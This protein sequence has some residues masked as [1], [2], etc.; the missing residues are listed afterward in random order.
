MPPAVVKLQPCPPSLFG[1]VAHMGC[2]HPPCSSSCCLV[3]PLGGCNCG[4]CG[5]AL[6]LARCPCAGI[7]TGWQLVLVRGASVV[8]ALA[9]V[10]VG[11]VDQCWCWRGVLALAL[12]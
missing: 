3:Q 5:S 2:L 4:P 12:A 9:V 7:G 1:G 11:P 6:V 10:I 8:M